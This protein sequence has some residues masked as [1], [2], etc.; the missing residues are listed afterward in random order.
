MIS[1]Y[2]LFICWRGVMV[3]CLTEPYTKAHKTIFPDDCWTPFGQKTTIWL[4]VLIYCTL[5]CHTVRYNIAL[6]FGLGYRI[7]LC[8]A[9][10]CLGVGE[11]FRRNEREHFCFYKFVP[12]D[13]VRGNLKG[14]PSRNHALSY[15]EDQKSNPL[16]WI[17]MTL[18]IT[19][20]TKHLPMKN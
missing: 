16:S 9:N 12:D 3:C 7:D 19:S 17:Q 11:K 10:T 8:G 4:S 13:V 2:Y 6:I 1:V 18:V 20:P 14:I 5:I 15:L